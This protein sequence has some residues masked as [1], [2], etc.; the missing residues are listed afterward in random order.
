MLSGGDSG[1]AASET[2]SLR[3]EMRAGQSAM[4]ATLNKIQ[5]ILDK[6]DKQGMPA[7]R[8]I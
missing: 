7:E 6:F 2:N 5:K 4:V 1:A 3:T 8:V